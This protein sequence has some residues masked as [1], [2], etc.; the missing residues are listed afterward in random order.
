MLAPAYPHRSIH[1]IN[2]L[3]IWW[4]I[5][6]LERTKILS[7]GKGLGL[8]CWFQCQFATNQDPPNRKL[9]LKNCPGC[10]TDVCVCVG[11]AH[12]KCRWHFTIAAQIKTG[13]PEGRASSRV[14]LKGF[15]P[16]PWLTYPAVGAAAATPFDD[17]RTSTSRL[18]LLRKDL[19]AFSGP[20][21]QIRTA[22]VPSHVDWMTTSCQ[23]WDNC[24][25]YFNTINLI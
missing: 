1:D 17:I 10:L 24:C 3:K 20:K 15:P 8:R 7:P 23:E 12:P 25:Y 13:I 16:D 19:W 9:H 21:D 6:F 5:R 14:L 4:L 18:P 22:E 11:G 2:T